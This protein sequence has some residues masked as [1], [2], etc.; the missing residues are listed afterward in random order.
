MIEDHRLK[1]K[2]INDVWLT[3]SDNFTTVIINEK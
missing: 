3:M 1:E 2:N